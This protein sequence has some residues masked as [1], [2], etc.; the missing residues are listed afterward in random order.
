[1]A[2]HSEWCRLF[3][4]L[5]SGLQIARLVSV[6]VN[7]SSKHPE[8]VAYLRGLFSELPTGELFEVFGLLDSAIDIDAT[9][10]NDE[11]EVVLQGSVHIR[12]GFDNVLDNLREK[13][14]RLHDILEDAAKITL[15]DLQLLDNLSVQFVPQVGYFVVV[16]R[17]DAHF[18]RGRPEYEFGYDDID[19]FSC[20]KSPLT[21]ELDMS[22]GDLRADISDRQ[23]SLMINLEDTIL[24]CEEGMFCILLVTL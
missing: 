3:H 22:V 5:S 17:D 20:F 15:Q 2:A 9:L 16:S 7:D 12:E 6:F 21:K 23:K 8:D 13:Y 11:N 14:A 19:G 1:M 4:S 24:A 10:G 18:L